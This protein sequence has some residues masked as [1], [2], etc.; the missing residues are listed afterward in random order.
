MA[1][2]QTWDTKDF[3]S[4]IRIPCKSINWRSNTPMEHIW[5]KKNR[6]CMYFV[7]SK[8]LE[9]EFKKSIWMNASSFARKSYSSVILI[10]VNLWLGIIVWSAKKLKNCLQHA[11]RLKTDVI[12]QIMLESMSNIFTKTYFSF[13]AC[14]D[15]DG[16]FHY[17]S[18][19]SK[20]N[21]MPQLI[22]PEIHFAIHYAR[23]SR[24][25]MH[26]HR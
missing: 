26:E 2:I 14:L 3:D 18:D 21:Y 9:I 6:L 8:L 23:F 25:A 16:Y 17:W 19:I 5:S 24:C 11:F 4:M 15:F 22:Q 20:L 1:T 13:S 12:L 10:I 7:I